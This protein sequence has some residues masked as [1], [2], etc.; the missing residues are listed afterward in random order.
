MHFFFLLLKR[1][2]TSL[3]ADSWTLEELYYFGSDY[4]M[5]AGI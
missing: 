3:Q 1:K 4:E 2:L 5:G